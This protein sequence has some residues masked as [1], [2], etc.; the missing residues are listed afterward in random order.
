MTMS[1]SLALYWEPGEQGCLPAIGKAMCSQISPLPATIFSANK[2]WGN[3]GKP[4]QNPRGAEQLQLLP[5]CA[6]LL[7]TPAMQN[8]THGYQ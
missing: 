1:P 4:S 5:S 6:V 7:M 8:C 2:Q 3:Q